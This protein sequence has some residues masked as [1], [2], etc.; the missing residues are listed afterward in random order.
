MSRARVVDCR[1][2]CVVVGLLSG[3]IGEPPVRHDAVTVDHEDRAARD[4]VDAVVLERLDRVVRL[5]RAV[6]RVADE[7]E[8][9]VVLVPVGGQRVGGRCS[10]R[11]GCSR[12]VRT[13]PGAPPSRPCRCSRRRRG[14]KASTTGSSPRRSDRSN[15]SISS[16]T[17]EAVKVG[18]S[19]P[20]S[21]I[22]TGCG[23][24]VSWFRRRQ[25]VRRV[26]PVRI[27]SNMGSP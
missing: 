20:T 21:V 1:V 26:G 12:R 2:E 9:E 3:V 7:R 4:R 10:R 24:E 27:S 5:D 23:D 19:S 25:R 18:A 22:Q 6:S 14:K 15:G 8:R 13:R 17:S 11:T 16:V